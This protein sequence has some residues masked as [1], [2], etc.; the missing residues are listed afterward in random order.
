M[1]LHKAIAGFCGLALAVA[2]GAAEPSDTAVR[3]LIVHESIAAYPGACPCP[4]SQDARGN[5][6]GGRSAWSR[7]AA[8]N[9]SA[10]WTKSP[11][12]RSKSGER[13]I[14][15][16]E[17]QEASHHDSLLHRQSHSSPTAHTRCTRRAAAD[18]ATDKHYL[19]DFAHFLEA[20][21]EA[22]K[23][24]WDTERLQPLR[25]RSEG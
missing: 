21:M 6:C 14:R 5:A 25:S 7:G 1:R 11:T 18:M 8:A 3:E 16:S 23:T 9:L 17:L 10:T 19:G 4:E 24:Y 2:A 12:R 15:Q 13:D 20:M 22:R